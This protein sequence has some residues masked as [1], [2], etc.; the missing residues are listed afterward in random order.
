[1]I[2]RDNTSRTRKE[3]WKQTEEK[4]RE[5]EPFPLVIIVI[6]NKITIENTAVQ[7]LFVLSMEKNN[8]EGRKEWVLFCL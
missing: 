1:M 4:K 7:C 8:G 6:L 3:K 5:E 2:Y